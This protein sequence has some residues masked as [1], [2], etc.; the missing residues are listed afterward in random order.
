MGYARPQAR[1]H[2][3]IQA[4][5]VFVRIGV[6]QRRCAHQPER[7]RRRGRHSLGK[8]MAYTAE[9]VSRPLPTGLLPR[10]AALRDGV[11]VVLYCGLTCAA[12]VLMRPVQELLW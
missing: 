8:T 2:Q 1:L 10:S 6:G 7:G 3:V 4:N 5:S 9:G 11:V 12:H